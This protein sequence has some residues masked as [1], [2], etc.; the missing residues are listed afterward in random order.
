M[1]PTEL[2]Q[3]AQACGMPTLGLTDHHLLTGTIEF[4]SACKDAGIQPV[5]GLEIDTEQGP[6]QLLATS[7]EGWSN[8]CR[9]SSA[10]ALREQPE[11]PCSL[12]L[13]SVHSKDLLALSDIPQPLID[14]FPDRLYVALRDVPKAAS[15]FVQARTLGLP[16]VVVH[17]VFYQVPEQ[18][19]LQKTLTAIRL[20]QTITTLS[21][22]VLAPANGWFMPPQLIE[23]RFKDYPDALLATHEIAERCRFEL[24]IGQSQMPIVPLPEGVTATQHLRNKAMVGANKL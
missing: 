23:E 9:L 11:K 15:L 5:I 20:N 7:L 8:L 2:A 1:T 22:E 17:P 19:K 6:L 16:A 3:A 14:I 18:A 21:D 4:V 10:L 13:L 24:P 12:D